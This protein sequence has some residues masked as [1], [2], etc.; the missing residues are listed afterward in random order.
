TAV[1]TAGDR[2]GLA[3]RVSRRVH[4]SI[5]RARPGGDRSEDSGDGRGGIPPWRRGSRRGPDRRMIRFDAA[6]KTYTSA[7]Q[8]RKVVALED[9]SL[10]LVPGEV[11]GIAGP[12]GA[13]KSTLISLLLGF[14]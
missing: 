13:G 6:G 1:A 10:E 9:F 3:C 4:G 12:N 8:R 11:V 5:C 14:L 7:I 2:G